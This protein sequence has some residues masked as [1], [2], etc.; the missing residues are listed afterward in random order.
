[1]KFQ[2][3]QA[4]RAVTN[5]LINHAALAMKHHLVAA[6]FAVMMLRQLVALQEQMVMLREHVD[7]VAMMLLQKRAPL[8]L[9]RQI[10]QSVNHEQN[11]LSMI[12]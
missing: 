2:Q 4:V 1:M 7:H 12:R 5:Q 11:E 6:E 9:R 8:D 3:S 10:S